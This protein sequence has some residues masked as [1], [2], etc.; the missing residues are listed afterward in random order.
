MYID[1]INGSGRKPREQLKLQKHTYEPTLILK[2]RYEKP[3]NKAIVDCKLENF[4]MKSVFKTGPD[5]NVPSQDMAQ[6][7]CNSAIKIFMPTTKVTYANGSTECTVQ[8]RQN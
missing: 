1:L 4:T 2:T 3:K 6:K 7:L 8:V 5:S